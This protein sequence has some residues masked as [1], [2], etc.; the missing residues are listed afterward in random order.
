MSVVTFLDSL[1][2]L[3]PAVTLIAS[4]STVGDFDIQLSKR[5]DKDYIANGNKNFFIDKAEAF[6]NGRNK[7]ESFHELMQSKSRSLPFLNYTHLNL[8]LS[9]IEREGSEV[10]GR[11]FPRWNALSKVINP[12]SNKTTSAIM[13][14]GDSRLEN[15]IGVAN[16]FPHVDLKHNEVIMLQDV[17]DV[18]SLQN[19]DTVE[20]HFDIFQTAVSDL[21]KLKK[22]LFDFENYKRLNKENKGQG[23]AIM[24]LLKI[25]VNQEFIIS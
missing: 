19:G 8:T 10:S 21:A 22:I 6:R 9:D 7:T 16:G 11:F 24:D 12:A 5:S 17:L 15:E 2:G 4:Q 13:V 20:I 25:D 14:A 23:E 3:A 1:I 18:L